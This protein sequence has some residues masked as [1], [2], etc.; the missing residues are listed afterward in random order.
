MR[1]GVR[2]DPPREVGR[3]SYLEVN[4]IGDPICFAGLGG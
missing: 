2:L 3:L 1:D 4:V